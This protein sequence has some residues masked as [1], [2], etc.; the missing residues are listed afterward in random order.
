M[1][2]KIP[3]SGAPAEVGPIPSD[4]S[5]SLQRSTVKVYNRDAKLLSAGFLTYEGKICT[6]AHGI[7][8][9]RDARSP[10]DDIVIYF[11][12]AYQMPHK[13]KV[14]NVSW[15]SDVAILELENAEAA[16]SV[17]P[18]PLAE[19]NPSP[20]G[21]GIGAF[22]IRGYPKAFEE[23]GLPISTQI[24]TP[25][26]EDGVL[27]LSIGATEE[28]FSGSPIWDVARECV[29]G[30]VIE[31]YG[32]RRGGKGGIAVAASELR[33]HAGFETEFARNPYKF[34]ECFGANQSDAELYFGRD[35][36]IAKLDSAVRDG[37]IT[38]VT[39]PSGAGKSSLIRAGL[40][41]ALG[42]AEGRSGRPLTSLLVFSAGNSPFL[43]LVTELVKR[44]PEAAGAGKDVTGLRAWADT[45]ARSPESTVELLLNTVGSN[46]VISFDQYERM[47]TECKDPVLREAMNEVIDL[48]SKAGIRWVI[49]I[50]DDFPTVI[51]EMRDIF[52]TNDVE[53]TGMERKDLRETI[54]RPAARKHRGFAGSVV[55]Q[56]LDAV[57]K[58]PA[59]LPLLQFS[60]SKLWEEAGPR[61]P[62][63]DEAILASIGFREGEN[64]LIGILS[65]YAGDTWKKL[66]PEEQMAAPN[67]LAKFATVIRI[68]LENG[69]GIGITF[70]SRSV[71][72]SELDRTSLSIAETLAKSHLLLVSLE[73]DT[74]LRTFS[75][76]HEVLLNAWHDLR[77]ACHDSERGIIY[78]SGEF[79]QYLKLFQLRKGKRVTLLPEELLIEAEKLMQGHLQLT[80]LFEG[81]SLRLI[82]ES[83]KALT[84]AVADKRRSLRLKRGAMAGVAALVGVGVVIFAI[85]S[86]FEAIKRHATALKTT[87]TLALADRD[88]PEAEIYFAKALSLVENRSVR[89]LLLQSRSAGISAG[90]RSRGGDGVPRNSAVSPDGDQVAESMGGRRIR[91]RP[92][93]G[94]GPGIIVVAQAEADMLWLSHEAD[95][96]RYLVVS[97]NSESGAFSIQ[98]FRLSKGGRVEDLALAPDGMGSAPISWKRRISQVS[99]DLAHSRF[100]VASEDASLKRFFLRG[101]QARLDWQK[102]GA[103]SIA[104]HGVAFNE[105]GSL[106]ATAGA[107]YA[108]RIWDME[109][110][111]REPITLWGHQDAVFTVAFSQGDKWVAS[112]GYDRAIRLW[113]VNPAIKRWRASPGKVDHS[114]PGFPEPQTARILQGHGGVVLNL[115]FSKDGTML[116]SVSKDESARIWDVDRSRQVLTLKPHNGRLRSVSFPGYG[117]DLLVAGDEGWSQWHTSGR[118]EAAKVWLGGSAVGALTF[119]RDSKYL[120]IGSASGELTRTETDSATRTITPMGMIECLEDGDCGVNGLATSPDGKWLAA[121]GQGRLVNLWDISSRDWRRTKT[122]LE[123]PGPVWGLA[124]DQAGKSL[125]T[126]SAAGKD[127]SQKPTISLWSAPEWKSQGMI[128]T[129]FSNYAITQCGA[130]G[131][132]MVGDAG[133]SIHAFDS[134]LQERS[135]ITNVSHGETNVWGLACF[136]ALGLVFSANSDGR[137]RAWDGTAFT[138]AF[139]ASEQEGRVNPTLNTVAVNP[140]RCQVAASGDGDRLQVYGVPCRDVPQGQTVLPVA[141]SYFGQEGTVWMAAY[142]A[143][144]DNLAYG[145]LDGFVKLLNLQEANAMVS[146]TGK[147]ILGESERLTG[148]R[149][150]P[151]DE[152]VPTATL[153]KE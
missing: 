134:R 11:D 92:I 88:Y 113:D 137:V 81:D 21:S 147:E 118:S 3:S 78:Y 49:A 28:G 112:G 126:T 79:S 139:Q 20:N 98:V 24:A 26:T 61:K 108:V 40:Y 29:I 68:P 127:P 103:H 70:T 129:P 124:F 55:D 5:V 80:G 33:K 95:G 140:K 143:N 35:S 114:V 96:L 117:G 53:V 32:L 119:T 51:K 34:L 23:K 6:T 109:N 37:R 47:R 62:L 91:I 27:L 48:S 63:I 7:D 14:R 39:G 132:W 100:L 67:L 138:S 105:D 152:V 131:Y 84:A 19:Y 59:A 121:G 69:A 57:V 18:L 36:D 89:D 44:F 15:P 56:L 60:L 94:T 9:D 90:A 73:H 125:A 136:D 82:Q 58:R 1:P 122:A 101:N 17:F 66:K 74:E 150:N 106:A 4:G 87:G 151:S 123:H 128:S 83:R 104:V 16:D 115:A 97:A 10:A 77:K 64:G 93:V 8:R 72:E 135:M 65:V 25:Y 46:G 41:R 111:A 120:V 22:T 110:T 149:I 13:V 30:M 145:G 102:E 71:A 2:V 75:L 43:N 153:E 133:G 52:F 142:S 45:L 54:V 141:A 38:L 12:G 31:G 144:G 76:A 99:F 116:A 148:L 85:Q 107:D 146:R 50:R 130:K 86:R 42:M